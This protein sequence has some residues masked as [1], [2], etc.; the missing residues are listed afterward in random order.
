[1]GAKVLGA[2][3]DLTVAAEFLM[4]AVREITTTSSVERNQARD[5]IALAMSKLDPI[6]RAGTDPDGGIAGEQERAYDPRKRR[7][8]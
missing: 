5:Y 8:G 2:I 3:H 6:V 4:V 7:P 1:M